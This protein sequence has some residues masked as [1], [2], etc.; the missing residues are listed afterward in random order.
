LRRIRLLCPLVLALGLVVPAA[1]AART[2][3]YVSLGDS[4]ARGV[5]P[6]AA[7]VSVDTTEGYADDVYATE[8]S[9]HPGLKLKKLGC[10]GETSTSMIKGGICRYAAGSQLAAARSFLRHHRGE[11]AFVTLDIGANDVDGCLKNGSIDATCLNAGIKAA[12]KNVPTIAKQ[13]RAAAGRAPTMVGMTYYDPFLALYV[14]GGTNRTL[15]LASVTLAGSFN[16]SLVAAYRKATFRI[17]DVAKAFRTNVQTPTTA[18]GLGTVPTNVA[19]ICALTWMCA[20]APRGPNIHA[21]A[22]GYALIAATFEMRLR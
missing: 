2:T 14:Q 11:I 16:D 18:P 7:G 21:R 1:A 10:P 4:L 13:L 22:P 12:G 5:Q 17:A 19:Q 20:P 15:A 3:W 9:T 8:R 6:N